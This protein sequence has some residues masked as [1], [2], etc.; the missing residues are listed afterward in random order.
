MVE[1]VLF[2]S[3][4]AEINEKEEKLSKLKQKQMTLDMNEIVSSSL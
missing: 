1:G 3:L 2:D 4:T